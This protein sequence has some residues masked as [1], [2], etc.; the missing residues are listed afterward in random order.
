MLLAVKPVPKKSAIVDQLPTLIASLIS[1][2]KSQISNL[3]SH[4]DIAVLGKMRYS[5][6]N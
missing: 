5:P 4:D 2:L 1:N 6:M 3:K